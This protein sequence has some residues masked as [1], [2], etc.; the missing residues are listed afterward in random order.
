MKTQ[1]ILVEKKEYVCETCN[2]SHEEKD[3][4]LQ[5]PRC[6][7]DI[8]AGCSTVTYTITFFGTLFKVLTCGKCGY[9]P[10]READI[11][12]GFI[13]LTDEYMKKKSGV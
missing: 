13:K 1:N 7:A 9:Y 8:C 3:L 5:C 2:N 11:V 4:I 10:K 6:R 12:S